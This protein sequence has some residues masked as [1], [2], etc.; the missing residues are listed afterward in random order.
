MS[1]K[2]QETEDLSLF[3]ILL[4]STPLGR[5]IEQH[6]MMFGVAKKLDD[7]TDNMKRFW[8]E[9]VVADLASKV[10][11]LYPEVN[12]EELQRDLLTKLIKR[13]AVHI[14]AWTR[15]DY[16]DGYK[17]A[18]VPKE[19]AGGNNGLRLF[20]INLGGY[21]EGEFEELH[22][23]FFVVAANVSE[24]MKKA[25]AHAF[26]KEY[27]ADNIGKGGTPHLDDQHKID[28]EADDIICVSDQLDS[29]YVLH[30]E[31]VESHTENEL[32]IGYVKLNYNN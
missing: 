22:K 24:A 17:V 3:A 26:M 9:P 2:N 10:K 5:N 29:G 30:L 15:V 27:A 4:G 12:K 6:D 28:F 11:K 1:G 8:H 31:Q 13:D 20:F 14:D 18:I 23:K 21:K 25:K 16:V 32:V 19:S 7:L